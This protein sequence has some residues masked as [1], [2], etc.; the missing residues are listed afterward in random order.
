MTS[1]DAFLAL[2][3]LPGIG[4]IRV[5]RLLERFRAPERILMATPSELLHWVSWVRG[6]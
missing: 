3:L 6:A 5:R 1:T 2:N 4:P